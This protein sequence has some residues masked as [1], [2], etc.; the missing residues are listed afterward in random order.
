MFWKEKHTRIFLVETACIA[1]FALIMG[2][3]F[4]RVQENRLKSLLIEHD[5]MIAS[6]LLEQGVSRQTAAGAILNTEL[7]PAGRE[8]LRQIGMSETTDI[9]LMPTV[10]SFCAAERIVIS[11]GGAL[12][13]ILLFFSIFRYL[14]KR[15]R[16]YREAVSV[17]ESYMENDFSRNLPALYEGTLFQLFSSIHFLAAMLK[18]KQEAEHRVK[19]FLKTTI[20]DISHQLK[21]PLAAGN[22][23]IRKLF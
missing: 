3:V 22:P 21:T 7:L 18:T 4:I 9:Y 19:E 15:D 6:A 23:C 5:A 2:L 20:S 17:I 14:Q 1:G 12:F 11:L 16:L 10:Y 8:L 13:F